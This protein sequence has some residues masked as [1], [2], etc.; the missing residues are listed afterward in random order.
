[1]HANSHALFYP[2]VL[3]AETGP[4][5]HIDRI[6]KLFMQNGAEAAVPACIVRGRK[7]K[8]ANLVD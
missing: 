2:K 6:A 4:P 8:K 3:A 1:M 7:S 5:L